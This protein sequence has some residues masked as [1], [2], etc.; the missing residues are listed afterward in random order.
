[1][2]WVY[3]IPTPPFKSDFMMS[4]SKIFRCICMHI[5]VYRA[6]QQGYGHPLQLFMCIKA[7][8]RGKTTWE[9]TPSRK[10]K[11]QNLKYIFKYVFIFT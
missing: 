2:M 10:D 7:E 5:G 1:M 11:E 8:E 6:Q 9:N 3:Y 4:I